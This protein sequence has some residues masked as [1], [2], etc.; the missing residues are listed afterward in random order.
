VELMKLAAFHMQLGGGGFPDP[1]IQPG[2]L[3]M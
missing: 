1:K 2:D 3:E